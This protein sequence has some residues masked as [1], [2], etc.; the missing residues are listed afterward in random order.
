MQPIG[1]RRRD[2]SRPAAAEPHA[3]PH[4]VVL[5]R[6]VAHRDDR[7]R[8]AEFFRNEW[9]PGFAPAQWSFTVTEAGVM[10]GVHLHLRH[11]DYFVL[12]EGRLTLGLRDLR[13]GSPTADCT[14]LL[15]LRDEDPLAVFIPHG[16]AHGFL[17]LARSIY[18]LGT[19]HCYDLTDELGC[20]W[21]D[22]D[23]GIGWPTDTARLSPRDAA[24][25]RM[26]E[27][28]ARVPPWRAG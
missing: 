18:V 7:G 8:V 26:R 3:L 15:E 19:S 23:L 6:L 2:A 5:R 11:D 20:H 24:L 17:S 13:A 25:P 27:L 28:A 4:G 21:R 1:I 22:P 12:L 16:V 14:A 9:S 10:R